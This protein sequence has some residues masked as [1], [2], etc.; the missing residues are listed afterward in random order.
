[1]PCC[2]YTKHSFPWSVK[3]SLTRPLR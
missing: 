3:E 2:S 1:M